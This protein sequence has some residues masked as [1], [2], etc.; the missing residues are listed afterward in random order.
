MLNIIIVG[1]QN[2]RIKI[3]ERKNQWRILILMIVRAKPI[4]KTS[5]CMYSMDFL[6]LNAHNRNGKPLFSLKKDRK[7]NKSNRKKSKNFCFPLI[8]RMIFILAKH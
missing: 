3:A 8:D 4:C 6:C 2:N 1:E 5:V 7:N